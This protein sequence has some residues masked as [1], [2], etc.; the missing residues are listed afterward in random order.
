M[1]R[2]SA[3]F[4]SIAILSTIFMVASCDRATDRESP[5][6]PPSAP[7]AVPQQ[8]LIGDVVAPLAELLKPPPP[9]PFTLITEEPLLGDLSLSKLLGI[10][11][12]TITVAGI[13]LDVPAGAVSVP[14]LFTV[15]ALPTPVIDVSLTALVPQLLSGL[16]ITTFKKPVT[17]TMS[18]ARATN[19]SDASKL[20]IVYYN[21]YSNKLEAL[22]STVDLEKKTVSAQ[23][24]HFSK[25]GMA[26]N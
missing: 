23:T 6:A 3:F 24:T 18:Y 20:V 16:N 21:Y 19:V 8:G 17:I 4:R 22:P 12:G 11:G 5:L 2:R 26:S 9:G 13:T 1:A 14:T 10:G 15:L 7:Q 25:Y